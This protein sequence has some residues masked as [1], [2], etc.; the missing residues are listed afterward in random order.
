MTGRP[1]LTAE[2][3][4]AAEQA[5][6]DAGTSVEELMERAG[7]A[8][9]EAAYR[10][11]GPMP[12][13]ILCGPG[14]NGGD[15]YVAARHLAERGVDVRVAALAEPSTA[16][17]R[18][19]ASSGASQSNPCRR[20][21]SRLHCL[22]D[23]LFGTGLKRGLEQSVSEQLSRLC[24]SAVA[25]IACDLPSGVE[26]DSG[27]ELSPVPSF[28]MTV[29]FGALKPAHL[30]HPPCTNAVGWCLPTSGSKRRRSWHEI[31]RPS[32]RRSIRTA[33]NMIAAWFMR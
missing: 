33:T 27:K 19:R 24:A 31:G 14:N 4:R 11:A 21:H 22:I 6:I 10:F 30:L 18:R 23:C 15:G 17:A 12:A 13:L 9:A 2:A 8:L 20:T 32:F 5:S 7:A 16:P 1:I 25:T 3:M 29:T 26:T 28:G